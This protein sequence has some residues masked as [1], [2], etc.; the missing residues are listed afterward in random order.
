MLTLVTIINHAEAQL[1]K[2]N[3]KLELLWDTDNDLRAMHGTWMMHHDVT[4]K[5]DI[6][7]LAEYRQGLSQEITEM[8][9]TPWCFNIDHDNSWLVQAR[10]ELSG[11][12]TGR[13]TIEA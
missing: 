5:A 6:Q 3:E 7:D 10:K 12:G 13:S 1:L 8:G 11:H 4:V 9:A 2:R